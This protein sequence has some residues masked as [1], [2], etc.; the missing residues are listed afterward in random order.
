MKRAL[1]V[2]GVFV[3]LAESCDV[4]DIV[5]QDLVSRF[6]DRWKVQMFADLRQVLELAENFVKINA[7]AG[8]GVGA[9]S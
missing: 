3:N 5:R 7:A 1:E 9:S 8:A 2:I 4:T 6:I